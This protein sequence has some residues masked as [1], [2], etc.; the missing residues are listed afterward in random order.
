[1]TPAHTTQQGHLRY[2]YYVCSRAQKRGW[3]TCPSKALSAGA[4]ERF[5]IEQL[6]A[7]A[8]DRK[9]LRDMVIDACARLAQCEPLVVPCPTLA[10]A[11][12]ALAMRSLGGFRPDLPGRTP[13]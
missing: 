9:R 6:Q 10:P 4:F 2:R 1:M 12:I 5:V 11:L 3:H 8:L 7:L 13:K